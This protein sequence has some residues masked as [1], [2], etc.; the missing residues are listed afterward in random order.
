MTDF[1][2]RR[3]VLKGAAAAG[4]SLIAAPAVAQANYPSRPITMR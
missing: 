4:A 2:D 3:T 1:I